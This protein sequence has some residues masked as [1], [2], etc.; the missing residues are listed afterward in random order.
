VNVSGF[1]FVCE[2]PIR[3]YGISVLKPLPALLGAYFS[4]PSQALETNLVLFLNYSPSRLI[5]RDLLD[6]KG[7]TYCSQIL[8]AAE[9]LNS[10]AAINVNITTK[11]APF[12]IESINLKEV[13]YEVREVFSVSLSERRVR[14]VEPDQLPEIQADRLSIIRIF[15]NWWTMP[16]NTGANTCRRSG[17]LRRDR[18]TSTP[19][20]Y[21]M[22]G[23]A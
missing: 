16:S 12:T 18:K 21:A 19:S 3:K 17:S 13:L 23:S 10:L 15:T 22:T 6:D 2:T 5:C 4:M 11:E 8:K 9:H 20:R 14:W 1:G 7:K